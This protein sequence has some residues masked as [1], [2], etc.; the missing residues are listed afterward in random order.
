MAAPPTAGAGRR[1]GT[2]VLRTIIVPVAR[3]VAGAASDT[4]RSVD[5]ALIALD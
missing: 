2:A 3:R 4:M 5:D 1:I